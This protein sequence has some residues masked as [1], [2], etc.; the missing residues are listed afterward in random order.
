MASA[1]SA[2]SPRLRLLGPP[3]L[4]VDSVAAPLKVPQKAIALLALLAAEYDVPLSRARLAELL[5]PEI[6]D[7]EARTNLRRQ[8]YLLVRR[9]GAQAFILTKNTAQWNDAFTPSDLAAFLRYA[10]E[11]QSYDRAVALW[12]GALASGIH[13]DALSEVRERLSRRYASLLWE[14]SRC[15][16]T[17]AN[18]SQALHYLEQL[19]AFD[20]LDDSVV[21]ALMQCR[22]HT[23]DRAGALAEYNALA[24]RLRLEL[25]VEPEAETTALFQ[26]I[27]YGSESALPPHNIT[28][29]FTS[30]IGRE[31][32]LDE[33]AQ[34][35]E[36]HRAVTLVGPAGVGKTR[37]A[38]R[39]AMNRLGAYPDGVWFVDLST[40]RTGA[41]MQARVAQVLEISA[42]LP[43]ALARKR[44]LLVL[45]NCEQ[46]VDEVRTFVQDLCDRT[47]VHVFATSRQRLGAREEF[48]I[49]VV[50]FS[51]PPEKSAYRLD[52]IARFPA[53]KLFIERAAAV[54]PS[55]RL[56]EDNAHNVADIVRRLD[57]L[58]LAIELVAARCGLLTTD[59]I[60]KRLNDLS[61]FS[62]KTRGPRHFTLEAAL[63]WSYELL[64]PLEQSVLRRLAVF[65]GTFSPEAA[66]A[67]CCDLIGDLIEPLSE[68]VESS[69]VHVRHDSDNVR[70]LLLETVRI[71]ARSAFERDLQEQDVWRRHACYYADLAGQLSTHFTA[72]GEI[73]AYRRCD[74]D[75]G[76]FANAVR[77]AAANDE[78]LA[79]RLVTALWRYWIFRWYLDEPRTLL[80]T[81][82]ESASFAAAPGDMR[83]RAYQAA[84]MLAKEQA[85]A[86]Q[87]RRYLSRALEESRALALPAREIEILNALAIVEFNHGDPR[88]AGR[89]YET[90]L[91]IQEEIGAFKAAAETVANLGAVAQSL[92]DDERAIELLNRALERFRATNNGRGVAYALRSL[93]LSCEMLERYD[94][95][96]RYGYECVAA[97]E[98]LDE[99][100]RLAD[101][102]QTLG[103]I[104]SVAGRSDEAVPLFARALHILARV[105][106]PI[107]TM[108]ALFGYAVCVN[109]LGERIESARAF[110]KALEL[111]DSDHLS[112]ADSYRAFLEK[113]AREVRDSLGER[114]Y[115]FACA[116]GRSRS[117]TE[118]AISAA[119]LPK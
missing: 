42:P 9:I 31:M 94:E 73:G 36:S 55:F 95:G 46:I 53:I 12:H 111:R 45:D 66:E 116:D 81:L 25:D 96:V 47:Q 5:W 106:H 10:A 56:F 14:L 60:L 1:P 109:R 49:S 29:T 7:E 84:G 8:L 37:L 61:A 40:A 83:V 102:L 30:F 103:N 32:E 48:V 117:I 26:S 74:P 52:S 119:A 15:A 44:M 82:L 63:E 59:G 85:D 69:L 88:E 72:A 108:L 34:A 50:P 105:E 23:G 24:Q 70:Y 86:P 78:L 110:A 57:G 33:I 43:T 87:A 6:A 115:E 68:L 76:N 98:A 90:C 39:S 65:S 75:F 67:V 89:I 51:T 112:L 4:V 71:F 79:L 92:G 91:R 107:F 118:F 20:S 21:R 2:G 113:V 80:T 16:R 77:W 27:V 35:F 62:D 18:H 64:S 93:A 28:S 104:L 11:P 99:Q 100:A 19:L 58:P 38:I 41:G 114:Q 97:Y 22:L 17:A 3:A 13:D 101:G 54:S